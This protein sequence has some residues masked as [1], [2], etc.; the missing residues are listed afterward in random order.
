M[1]RCAYARKVS[2]VPRSIEV[3]EGKLVHLEWDDG[4]VA[5]IPAPVLRASCPCAGC[6]ERTIEPV[7]G[8]VVLGAHLVGAYAVSFTFSP[9]GHDTGIYP[10]GWLREIAIPR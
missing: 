4:F 6:R 8:T 9:D 5:D 7:D 3:I 2:S 1:A 10:F